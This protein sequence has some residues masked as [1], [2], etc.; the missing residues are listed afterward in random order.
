[1]KSK[2]SYANSNQL[3]SAVDSRKQQIAMLPMT[4]LKDKKGFLKVC[5]FALLDTSLTTPYPSAS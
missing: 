1:M 2:D 5:N 3:T 4:A